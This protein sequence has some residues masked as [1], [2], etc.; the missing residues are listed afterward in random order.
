M[1]EQV[2][3]RVDG[4]HLDP[5]FAHQPRRQR[6]EAVEIG[7]HA[8]QRRQRLHRPRPG[9]LK[10]QRETEIGNERERV[11][12]IDRDRRQHREDF[13]AEQSLQIFHLVGAE[14]IRF[15]DHHVL[16]EQLLAQR[17]PLVLLLELQMLGQR[18]DFLE[19]LARCQPVRALRRDAGTDLPLEA[20]HA[21]HE[22]LVEVVGRD[23]DE[24]HPLEQR[25]VGVPGL[26]QHPHVEL[27]PT[28]FT[29]DEAGRAV[30]QRLGV[31]LRFRIGD[32]FP[33][34]I[35]RRRLPDRAPPRSRL[36]PPVPRQQYGA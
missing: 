14:V 26:L 8:H 17:L 33:H 22:E 12:R 1:Q 29:V 18:R 30:P 11:R 10:G 27:Q 25:V 16:G 15:V 5:P 36:F 19:L 28:D 21:H 24:P 6:D 20:G 35:H 4:H 23:R 9:Q 13:L 2:D 7:W 32:D 3:Q 34:L 31:G